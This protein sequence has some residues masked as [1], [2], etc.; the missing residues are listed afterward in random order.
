MTG[1]RPRDV[2]ASTGA[3][4]N[5]ATDQKLPNDPHWRLVDVLREVVRRL[6]ADPVLV[7]PFACA[8]L[9][10]VS[11]DVWRRR[12]PLP[13]SR[14]DSLSRTLEVQATVVPSGVPRTV[15]R[16]DALVDL[17]AT[18]L[19]A[20]V[21][22]ELLVPLVIATAGWLT[23]GRASTR[24]RTLGG[25]VRYLGVVLAVV[26]VPTLVDVPTVDVSSLFVGL[27]LLVVGAFLT[28]RVF[29]VPGYVVGGDSLVTAVRRSV[30]ESTGNALAI[31]GLAVG[32]GTLSWALAVLFGPVGGGV[33]TAV[34]GVV[35]AI[36]L[37]V[38]VDWSTA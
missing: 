5:S 34:G 9:V 19:V 26:T 32:F 11:V 12:D 30:R 38:L 4:S 8:G 3:A 7:L 22:L 14:P 23:V 15:R 17:Q 2:D 31:L 25:L 16:V 24:G 36:A 35:H 33:S 20:G 6:R 13:V 21:G 10:L 27:L 37:A 28:I 1:Q 18:Y 29:L